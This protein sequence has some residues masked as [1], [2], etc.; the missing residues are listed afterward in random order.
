MN[1]ISFPYNFESTQYLLLGNKGHQGDTGTSGTLGATGDKG[2]QG[3]QGRNGDAGLEGAKGESGLPGQ[4]GEKGDHGPKG[5]NGLQGQKGEKGGIGPQGPVGLKGELGFDGPAGAHHATNC[6]CIKLPHVE[7]LGMKP[8]YHIGDKVDLNCNASG[9]PAPL[10]TWQRIGTSGHCSSGNLTTINGHLVLD[11]L[12]PAD[13]GTYKCVAQNSYGSAEKEVFIQSNDNHSVD[14]DFEIDLCKWNN[15]KEDQTDWIR[16][17]GSTETGQTGPSGDHTSNSGYYM[18]LEASFDNSG[19]KADFISPLLPATLEACLSF[20]YHMYGTSMG[21]IVVKTKTCSGQES[22]KLH[23]RGNQ[24]TSWHFG[25]VP[26]TNMDKDFQIVIEAIHGNGV[27]GDAAIDDIKYTP[28]KCHANLVIAGPSSE[29]IHVQENQTLLLTC[30]VTGS[31]QTTYS[32][33]KMHSCSRNYTATRDMKVFPVH[34]G[35]EG[36]YTCSATEKGQTVSK[37]FHVIV[38]SSKLC[39]ETGGHHFCDFET[40]LCTWGLDKRG[41]FNWTSGHAPTPSADTGPDVDHTHGTTTGRFLFIET[42]SPQARGDNAVLKS[43]LLPASSIKCLT[44]WYNMYGVDIDNLNIYAEDTCTKLTTRV[45]SIHGNQGQAWH[46]L[47]LT[48][49]AQT[50]DYHILIEGTTG[51]S[52]HGDIAIDDVTIANGKCSGTIFECDFEQNECG[53]KESNT[54]NFDWIRQKG[55][56]SST[57]TGPDTDHTTGT[58][59]GNYIYIESSSPRVTGDK[60]DL[61][62]PSLD[63]KIAYCLD[64]WYSMYGGSMGSMKVDIASP[65]LS[66]RR[67]LWSMSGNQGQGWHNAKVNV[68]PQTSAF[69]LVFEGVRGVDF[70]SD[71]AL[72]DIKVTQGTCS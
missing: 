22:D 63:P 72:D 39:R 7:V 8:N 19:D 70:T 25:Q 20:W 31:Q 18:Y 42:S 67:N 71:A 27:Y 23:L 3:L 15:S 37:E 58:T 10:V 17:R 45:H 29:T 21:D 66:I 34:V 4:K 49:P 57:G 16:Y 28:G 32:W 44:L 56:T 69:V 65:T 46:K 11:K 33:T 59:D 26:I 54:D 43:E 48:I 2:D 6:M 60:A 13:I 64:F 30:P 52:Y 40:N 55:G 62:T 12:N 68:P 24:G 50:N 53:M 41:K 35:D 38:D 9:Q 61:S 36:T 1:A 51:T 5:S 47:F 14:C